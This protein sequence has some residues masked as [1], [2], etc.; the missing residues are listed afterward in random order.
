[1]IT[2]LRIY[3]HPTTGSFN[4]PHALYLFLDAKPGEVTRFSS[5]RDMRNT[6]SLVRIWDSLCDTAGEAQNSI[7]ISH[8]LISGRLYTLAPSGHVLI[9]PG[10]SKQIE[11]KQMRMPNPVFVQD[12]QP[13]HSARLG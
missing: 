4:L 7:F 12:D 2:P 1:M 6:A 5:P 8:S 9:R 10:R 3:P 11:L 13:P